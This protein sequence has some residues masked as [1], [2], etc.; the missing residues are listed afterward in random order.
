V[1]QTEVAV[2]DQVEQRQPRCLVLLGDRDDKAQV[3][4]HELA[5]GL[6]T[7]PDG[8]PQRPSAGRRV[9][10]ATG[11]ERLDGVLP[12][13][14]RHRQPDLVVLGQQGVSTDVGQIQTNEI[15][16]IARSAISGHGGSSLSGPNR[17]GV[18]APPGFPGGP[19]QRYRHI[20]N[21]PDQRSTDRQPHQRAGI[22][23]PPFEESS[24]LKAHTA[25]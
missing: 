25:N 12:G 7:V 2:L 10:L 11:V 16:I 9:L 6:L 3:G 15:P 24:H 19:D 8:A 17:V 4:P 1:H 13:F 22:R 5:L 18:V 20:A 23:T 21:E 14:D